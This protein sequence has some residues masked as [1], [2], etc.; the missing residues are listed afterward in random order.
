MTTF[1][2]AYLIV[3]LAMAL[4]VLWLAVHQRRIVRAQQDRDWRLPTD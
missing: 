1:A 4:Y 3:S 2:A